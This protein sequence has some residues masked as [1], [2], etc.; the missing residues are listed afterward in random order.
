MD[1]LLVK[2]EALEVLSISAA[3]LYK[4]CTNLLNGGINEDRTP[5]KQ[6]L[7]RWSWTGFLRDLFAKN[8]GGPFDL[9]TSARVK[10]K[11]RIVSHPSFE[12]LHSILTRF[13]I[14]QFSNVPEIF[15]NKCLKNTQRFSKCFQNAYYGVIPFKVLECFLQSWLAIEHPVTRKSG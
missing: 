13:F 12:T 4:F 9:P 1:S 15:W 2:L 3:F 11:R 14:I 5:A 10:I 6:S 7:L 8:R